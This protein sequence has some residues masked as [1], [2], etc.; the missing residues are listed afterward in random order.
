MTKIIT[1]VSRFTTTGL[2]KKAVLTGN[3]CELVFYK[4]EKVAKY[5]PSVK[6]FGLATR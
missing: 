3:T 4:G 1:A 5:S 6:R 2:D